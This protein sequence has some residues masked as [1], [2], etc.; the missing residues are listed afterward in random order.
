MKKV[1]HRKYGGV[2]LLALMGLV[3]CIASLSSQKAF[4]REFADR[5]N[6]TLYYRVRFETL[7]ESPKGS[8]YIDLF[9]TYT[10]EITQLA[11]AHP[12]LFVE[13]LSIIKHWEPALDAF[14]NGRGSEVTIT[15]ADVQGVLAY[16]EHLAGQAGP[17]LRSVIETER[18]A[19]PLETLAGMTM[20]QAWGYLNTD[21][22]F[23]VPGIAR[24]RLPVAPDVS[25]N[26]AAWVLPEAPQ[27]AL[28]FDPDVWELVL[29]DN[30]VANSWE[31]KH[32]SLY[33]CV[34]TVPRV[35]ADPYSY[36][37]VSTKTLGELPYEVRSSRVSELTLYLVY[38]PLSLPSGSGDFQFILYPGYVD[39][40]ACIDQ[41]DV[42]LG[43]V[44]VSP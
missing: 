21:P 26:P 22:R 36:F 27:L 15:E 6:I 12:A 17:E 39:T 4:A 14:V 30:G 2:L 38:R 44:Q 23:P 25:M 11:L 40:Q 3:L 41:A 29:W 33:D 35:L 43:L 8:Y 19:L 31:L 5:A 20:D 18:S 16:L 13:S 10:A 7:G 24:N 1:V 34:V 37:D 42:L 9:D 32:R 28:D